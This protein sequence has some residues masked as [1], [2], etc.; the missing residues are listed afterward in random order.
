MTIQQIAK[1]QA[2]AKKCL[3]SKYKDCD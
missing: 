1:A 3:V 2:M